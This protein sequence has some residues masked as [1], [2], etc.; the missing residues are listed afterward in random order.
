MSTAPLP[1][2]TAPAHGWRTPIVIIVCGCA[3]SFFAFGVRSVS[4]F[5]LAP[6]SESFHWGREVFA[7]SVAL[8]MLIWGAA[9]PVAG[10]IADKFGA[11]RVLGTGAILYA[12]GFALM[13]YSSEPWQMHLTAGLLV[14][15]GLAGTSITIVMAVMARLARP[16]RR[17]FLVGL[18]T[19][20][21]S[22]GQFVILPMG[23]AFIDAY[24]WQ[25]ACLIF[26]AVAIIM[27][28]LSAAIRTDTRPAPGI[29]EQKLMHALGEAFGFRSY[30]LVV[31]GFFVCGFQLF[32]ILAHLPAYL[33]DRGL[34]SKWAGYTLALVGL[35]NVVGGVIAG[36]AGV[37]WP[38]RLGLATI[39]F[40]RSVITV[41]FILLPL[42]PAT[43]MIY[44][45]VMGVLWLST[46]PLTQGLVLQFFGLR[47]LAT[48]FGIA[49]FS[50]QVGGFLGVWLGGLLFDMYKSYD[51]VWW[52]IVALGVVAALLHMPIREAP[53]PRLAAAASAGAR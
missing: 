49:F 28:P 13:A 21:T 18:C 25:T 12:A 44:G 45:S 48:L 15:M 31:I 26:G 11:G 34:D 33:S 40:A 23:R 8:Q 50:H 24:G 17:T 7:L 46:M 3:L 27:L 43:A 41:L 14:G 51:V 37:R 35:T 9:T 42:T 32:F 29:A 5:L 4:G 10:A 39:Y 53:A 38:K 52:L 36:Y 16:E 2:G 30:V 47:W 20:V 1:A 19:A 6:I 22:L